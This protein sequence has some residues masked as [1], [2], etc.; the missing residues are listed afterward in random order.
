MATLTAKLSLSSSNVSTDNLSILLSNVLTVG[1]DY[2]SFRKIIASGA[3]NL[4]TANI[5]ISNASYGKAYVLLHNTSI[6]AAEII[7]IGEN[8]DT[9][10]TLDY[11]NIT[12]GAG[13]FAFYPWNSTVDLV[14]DAASGDPVLEVMIFEAA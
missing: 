12:L 1:G 14:A 2:R 10:A 4:E 7:N 6:V 3:S 9:N 5:V 13:E 11:T 8:A